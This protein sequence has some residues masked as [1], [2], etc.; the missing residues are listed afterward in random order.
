MAASD[1]AQITPTPGARPMSEVVVNRD[2]FFVILVFAAVGAVVVFCMALVVA[3]IG[4]RVLTRAATTF[5]R[6]EPRP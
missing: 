5:P 6:R 1:A 3:S 2:L 4:E